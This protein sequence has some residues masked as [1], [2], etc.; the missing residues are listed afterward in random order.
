MKCLAGNLTGLDM[1]NTFTIPR[2]DS[3]ALEISRARWAKFGRNCNKLNVAND[4]EETCWGESPSWGS[5]G[6][7]FLTFEAVFIVAHLQA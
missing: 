3:T 6:G 7:R 2:G 1:S 4:M 5:T